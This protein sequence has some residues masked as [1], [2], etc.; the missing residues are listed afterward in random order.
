MEE[1][2]EAQD[3]E[4]AKLNQPASSSKWDDEDA[5]GSAPEDWDASSEDEKTP[6]VKA[7]KPASTSTK[8]KLKAAIAA[9]ESA[10]KDK[11]ETVAERKAREQAQIEEADLANAVDLFGGVSVSKKAAD[12]LDKVPAN[13][14][15]F[16]EW[17]G[18]LLKK[19]APFEVC[20]CLTSIEISTLRILL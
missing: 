19:T 16:T 15:E 12:P 18:H 9:K 13:R 6:V 14:G 8:K 11:L 17:S 10:Q 3:E 5:A 7:P 4:E 2:W 1:D 20:I